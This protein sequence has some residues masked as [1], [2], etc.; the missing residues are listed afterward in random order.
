MTRRFEVPSDHIPVRVE[1]D[2]NI[3]FIALTSVL[4][5]YG[6]G[7]TRQEA[8]AMLKSEIESLFEELQSGDLFSAE[9]IARKKFL[10]SLP[11]SF[12]DHKD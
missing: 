3:G 4:P 10:E 2:G 5:I 1:S 6:T 8:I 11:R 9:W 12:D 7:A